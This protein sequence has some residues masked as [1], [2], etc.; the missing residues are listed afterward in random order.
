MMKSLFSEQAVIGGPNTTC[1]SE[2]G[3]SGQFTRGT[4][5]SDGHVAALKITWQMTTGNGRRRAIGQL[6]ICV[7]PRSFKWRRMFKRGRLAGGARLGE[8]EIALGTAEAKG[9]IG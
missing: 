8:G 9:S 6:V 4:D 1:Y 5:I 2:H 3:G 7:S